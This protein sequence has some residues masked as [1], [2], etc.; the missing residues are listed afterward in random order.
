MIDSS[1]IISSSDNILIVLVAELYERTKQSLTLPYE[2]L[3][4]LRPLTLLLAYTVFAFF[5]KSI[6]MAICGLTC[7][8]LSACPSHTIA[9]A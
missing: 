1:L 7:L 5:S 9:D 4:L 2:A 8:M 6:G 3:L